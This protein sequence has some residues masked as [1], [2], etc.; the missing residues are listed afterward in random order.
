MEKEIQSGKKSL[1][2]LAVA[3][4]IL[5]VF[6]VLSIRLSKGQPFTID[7]AVICVEL[8]SNRKPYKLRD[9]I[10][11]GTR[12][13][14]L[15]FRYS[16]ATEGSPLNVSWYYGENLVVSEHLKLISKDGSKA[17]YLLK[18]DGAPLPVGSYRVA[19]SSTA[20]QIDELKFAIEKKKK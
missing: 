10:R 18:E 5:V 13:V 16:N 1:A 4:I 14:C 20:G 7:K 17:F 3:V 19:V 8:D 2:I 15:W 11:Y 6:T 12:Q 9:V